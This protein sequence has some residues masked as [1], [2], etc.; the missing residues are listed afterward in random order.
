MA[1]RGGIHPPQL[2]EF[3][4]GKPIETMPL[5]NKVFVF[6]ANHTGNPSKLIVSPGDEVK[7]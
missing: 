5:P 7:A 6:L 4:K 1:F 3:T 2:K